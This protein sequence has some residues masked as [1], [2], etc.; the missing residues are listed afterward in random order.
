VGTG[1]GVSDF[2]PVAAF[3]VAAEVP[4]SISTGRA[5]RG[6]PDVA[7]MAAEQPGYRIVVGGEPLAL[8]GTSAGTPLW[9]AVIAIADASRTAPLGLVAPILYA[10]RDT[11]RPITLGDN[12]AG[13][14][15]YSAGASWSACTGLGVP[16]G[17]RLIESLAS[18]PSG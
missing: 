18:A 9:A 3:Q 1:G 12:K 11:M 6:V 7:A 8:G 17:A 4:A 16:I 15:G 14:V 2:F 10:K 5:G 13:S